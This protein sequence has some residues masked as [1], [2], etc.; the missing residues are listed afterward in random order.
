MS[1]VQERVARR[2]IRAATEGPL[3]DYLPDLPKL[4]EALQK[5]ATTYET[6]GNA[7]VEIQ[8]GLDSIA[9]GRE[10]KKL[11]KGL[12]QL[13]TLPDRVQHLAA[14]L[15]HL[16]QKYVES[17]DKALAEAENHPDGEFN[18]VSFRSEVGPLLGEAR[19]L[20]KL[21]TSWD[22][23]LPTQESLDEVHSS[24]D[25]RKFA[26]V[27]RLIAKIPDPNED[28]YLSDIGDFLQNIDSEWKDAVD[29]A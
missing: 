10:I 2:H 7:L 15:G 8:T 27:T 9:L 11:Q 12:V 16:S 25:S 14:N 6:V 29:Y 19:K 26:T 22:E 1:T 4:A 17:V 20:D 24:D 21:I 23:W 28:N 18:V 3:K 13:R 5:I